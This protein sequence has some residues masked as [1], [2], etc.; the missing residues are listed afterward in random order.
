MPWSKRA[1][2]G[3]LAPPV[4]GERRAKLRLV[5]APDREIE[6]GVLARLA[7][8]E[9]VERPTAGDSPRNTGCREDFM[10]GG[11]PFVAPH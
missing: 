3:D 8:E 11:Q 6:V 9:Q 5:R 2:V 1:V 10:D 7:S 4:A